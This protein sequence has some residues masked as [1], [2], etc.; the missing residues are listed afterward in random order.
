MCRE[1]TESS[2]SL[3]TGDGKVDPPLQGERRTQIESRALRPV[4]AISVR[5]GTESQHRL[6]AFRAAPAG[7]T[8]TI[9]PRFCSP[10]SLWDED[11]SEHRL[12]RRMSIAMMLQKACHSRTR[13]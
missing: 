9:H 11:C 7:T 12:G 2:C 5:N 10:E 6:G 1:F 3:V 4:A 8:S 13:V